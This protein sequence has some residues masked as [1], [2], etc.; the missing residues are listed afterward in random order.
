MSNGDGGL[1]RSGQ[2][3][4]S[5]ASV[6]PPRRRR[7]RF[8]PI[9]LGALVFAV[10]LVIAP[11]TSADTPTANSLL[12]NS[13]PLSAT[14]R[15]T[16]T[17]VKANRFAASTTVATSITDVKF[18]VGTLRTDAPGGISDSIAPPLHMSRNGVAWNEYNMLVSGL[19]FNRTGTTT[20]PIGVQQ[21]MG[22]Y[23]NVRVMVP[24][25]GWNGRLYFWHHGS[26]DTSLLA[27]TSAVEPELLLKR[28]WAVAMADFQ[29]PVAAQQ[30]PNAA[31][32]S[33]WKSIDEFYLADPNNYSTYNSHPTWWSNPNGV[34]LSDGANLRNVVGLVKNLLYREQ[35]Q[36]P[37]RTYWFGWSAGA[38]GRNVTRHWPRP[39]RQL[40]GQTS[41]TAT[42]A[43]GKV[44]DGFIGMEPTFSATASVDPVY[45]IVAPYVFIDGTTSLLSLLTPNALS[46]S[47]KV[48]TALDNTV[49]P[50]A[51]PSLSKNINDWVR[52]YTQKYGDHDWSGRFFQ[53]LYSGDDTDPVYYDVT[54]PLAQ[55]LNGAG[56]GR[57]F[58]WVMAKM[59]RNSPVYLKDWADETKAGWGQLHSAYYQLNDGYFTQVFTDLTDWVENAVA[60]PPSRIDPY[61][62]LPTTTSYPNLP[63]NDATQD[64][65][66][67]GAGANVTNFN[68]AQL[69]DLAWLRTDPGALSGSG[70]L[71]VAP[72]LAARWG[73]YK[74][75][76]KVQLI[77]P[78]TA[79]QL[80][81]GYHVGNID[82]PGYADY[83]A[84]I[85]AFNS[86]IQGLVNERL[87][88]PVVAASL[89]GGDAALPR[90]PFPDGIAP[91]TTATKSPPTNVLGWNSG[92]ATVTL[93]AVDDQYG[94]G[95]ATTYYAIDNPACTPLALATCVSYSDPIVVSA[96]GVHT[97]TYFS[98]DNA[99][100]VEAAHTLTVKI[101][102]A[103][104]ESCITAN[105]NGPMTVSAGQV[106]CVAAGV[107]ISG[108]LTVRAGG[109]LQL[110]GAT[111]SGPVRL[112]GPLAVTICGSRISGPV[113]V[114]GS[115]G[116]VV[117]GSPADGCAGNSIS[118]PVT[119]NDNHGGVA[120][121]ANTVSGPVT[122]SGNSG[123]FVF[124]GNTVSGPVRT[125]GNS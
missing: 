41:T 120:F 15:P 80:V 25:T 3:N 103:F 109:A 93:S 67:L 119:V 51:D 72:H 73:I 23:M 4:A 36:Q 48:K 121:V 101:A 43:S 75:N 79:S 89:Q 115:S 53:V 64:S 81:N 2:L 19:G 112:E 84:Y 60:P 108:P 6:R 7:W 32:D 33:F 9:T 49:C 83:P 56:H 54:K 100:N 14:L 35:G 102:V 38:S 94:V 105:R 91:T 68:A 76:Y 16:A 29:A 21:G 124:S 104:T 116:P 86:S 34:A 46:I 95:V 62:L 74:V 125:T 39:G 27:F 77:T 24:A 1:F 50:C 22:R 13:D 28:G 111:V 20:Y 8:A 57:H 114:S 31:D 37:S 45:P 61:V 106:V 97:L 96:L 11:G 90:L 92:A 17:T 71:V 18:T 113:S 85:A 5:A 88:D 63:V 99:G 69:A 110:N 118:G 87:F 122:I 59:A 58:N 70:G 65:L 10:A 42:P 55:R 26:T 30:N 52:L 107:K 98:K 44:F 117:I 40:H 123:G 12:L 82:F 78:F 47:H 66:V